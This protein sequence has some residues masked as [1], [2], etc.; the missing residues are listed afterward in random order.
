MLVVEHELAVLLHADLVV[1]LVDV[2]VD[3]APLP[4][5]L[6][7]VLQKGPTEGS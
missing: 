7:L 6:G 3:A 2:L 5:H 1:D 4:Q